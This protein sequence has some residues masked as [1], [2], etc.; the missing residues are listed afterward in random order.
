MNSDTLSVDYSGKRIARNTTYNVL[1]LIIPLA[2]ALLTIPWLVE[3]LGKER[4]G[5]ILLAWTVI[6]YFNLFDVGISAA[7]TRFVSQY[8]A[9]KN[10]K[11]LKPLVWTSIYL[12]FI[13]GTVAM[14]ILLA[15]SPWLVNKVFNTPVDLREETL[16]T[17]YLLGISLPFLIMT[18][19]VKGIFQA[20]QRFA[21]I[22]MITVPA[23]AAN[24][25]GP[26][27]ISFFI[28]RLDVIIILL[29]FI[30]TVVFLVHFGFLL[31]SMPML[32][33]PVPPSLTHAKQ[34]L[35]YGGWMT[36]SRTV[37]PM[38]VYFDRFL[39]ASMLSLQ[40]VA[41]YATPLDLS[42]RL[43]TVAH[44]FII[45]LFP[46][47][48]AMAAQSRRRLRDASLK[49]LKFGLLAFVPVIA[50]VVLFAKP[51][52]AFW[53]GEDFAANS[54]LILQMVAIGILI[55][56]TAHFPLT[57]LNA[58]GRPD[59]PAKL[60]LVELPLYY[61]VLTVLIL[62]F[63]IVGAALAWCLRVIFD[64]IMLSWFAWSR[65]GSDKSEEHSRTIKLLIASGI[66]VTA[67]YLFSLIDNLVIEIALVPVAFLIIGFT[68]WKALLT[69]VDKAL[70][71]E[72]TV[73]H[74]RRSRKPKEESAE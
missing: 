11:A 49:S 2:V 61:I 42:L 32:R 30:R 4:F 35:S 15:I 43:L 16:N 9:R 52:F 45:V 29:V 44:S 8:L 69:G 20:Q 12:L 10:Y 74:F 3:N 68:T 55:N 59:I 21:L 38:M 41:Y 56:F 39:I 46:A 66:V 18:A 50:M 7:V 53:L 27:I 64:T 65:L 51:F 25:L 14:I 17:F 34:V 24:Y 40:A 1:G 23:S 28:H 54:S 6:G 72:L 22:N 67:F 33:R 26:L 58:L 63:G 73:N 37:G 5:V 36:V 57:V 48:S 70:I 60:H 31:A 47:F 62:N 19:G 71:L 13:F